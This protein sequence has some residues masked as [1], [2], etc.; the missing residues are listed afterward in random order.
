MSIIE[1]IDRS[2]I[3]AARDEAAQVKGELS[4]YSP[5]GRFLMTAPEKQ[6]IR[7]L[8][9]RLRILQSGGVN[10]DLGMILK[11]QREKEVPRWS[12]A[13][14]RYPLSEKN[15]GVSVSFSGDF[16]HGYMANNASQHGVFTSNSTYDSIQP[17]MLRGY[18]WSFLEPKVL[19]PVGG[20]P[21]LPAKVRSLLHSRAV[22]KSYAH[23]ILYQPTK[24]D[25]LAPVPKDPDP[26]LIVR[27]TE[28]SPWKCLAVWGHDGPHIEEF[29]G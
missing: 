18:H 3:E 27:W 10:I 1:A 9:E 13:N 24:W 16:T 29:I 2:S 8:K 7:R 21:V 17:R 20:F 5:V 12:I 25:R 28:D 23:L 26:A 14:P 11:E 19:S 15:G 6:E 22:R 4:Q